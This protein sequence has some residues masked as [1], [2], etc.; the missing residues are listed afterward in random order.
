MIGAMNFGY[1]LF[2]WM[3]VT[4][5]LGLDQLSDDRKSFREIFTGSNPN[6]ALFNDNINRQEITS[7]LLLNINHR[8]NSDIGLTFTGGHDF[9][10]RRFVNYIQSGTDLVIPGV[11][12]MSNVEAFDPDYEFRTLRRLVGVFGDLKLDYKNYLFLGLTARNEWSST[13]PVQNRSFFYPGANASLV[14]TDAFDLNSS[15]LSYGK[16]RA[17]FAQ[18]ARDPLPYQTINTFVVPGNTIAA[19]YGDGF[20]AQSAPLSFPFNGIPGYTLNNVINNPNLKAETTSEFEIGAELRFFRERLNLDVTYFSNRNENGIIPV[21]ISPAAGATNVVVNS[22]LTTVKGVEVGLNIT[23]IRSADFNW[24]A[25]ITF[26]RIRSKVVETYPG[27]EQIYLG[28]FTGNP[29]IFAVKGLRYGSI[30]G[31]GYNRDEQGNI[32]VDDDGF[33]LFVDGINL[34]HIEPDWTGGLRNTLSYK[35]VTL[36]FLLDTRQGGYL[37]NGTEELLDFYGVSAKTAT[38]EADFIFPG[39]KQSNK[40]VN[41]I[42]VKQ[43]ATW[44]NFAQGNEEYVY[45]N[46]WLRLR[47]ANLSYNL[48]LGSEKYVKSLSLGIYG[49]NLW[50]KTDVPHVDPESSSFG[51]NNGQGATRMSFPTLRSIG[52]NVRVT[53]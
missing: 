8:L 7:T 37:Y 22:G 11:P 25:Y 36:D 30:I 39:I 6:G 18:T 49:R 48:T 1:K 35:N 45:E 38:R 16:I 31:T 5:R 4:Y 40:Q 10:Q 33:P 17:G 24:N 50:L 52:F 47:E 26:S 13:L 51:T 42:V 20:V 9:N 3:D 34:G 46:N 28:G 12:H 29:A 27:V 2:P 14:F 15:I 43:D 23:P 44:W 53:F 32:L 19:G 21:D 41:D